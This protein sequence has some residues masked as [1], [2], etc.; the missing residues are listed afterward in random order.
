MSGPRLG[1][2]LRAV[3][4]LVPAEAHRVADVGAGHGA[5]SAHLAAAG[6]P[7]VIA[8]ESQDGP[9]AEL[10]RN[11]DAWEAR[12]RVDVRRGSGLAPLR[13]DEVDAVVVSGVSARTALAMCADAGR[14]KVRW[15]VLQC[16][17]GTDQV[18]PWMRANGW[19]VLTRVDAQAGRRRYPIW[20]VEVPR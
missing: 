8:T 10:C 11:L 6:V 16:M 15:M 18:E 14:K 5:L 2:R 4:A 12:E 17:Q 19:Q 7:T 3:L 1:G 9:L 20:L 13:T